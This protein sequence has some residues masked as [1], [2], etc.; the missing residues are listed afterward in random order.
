MDVHVCVLRTCMYVYVDERA[1]VCVCVCVCV[2]LQL[3]TAIIAGEH[4]VTDAKDR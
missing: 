2:S 3:G 4:V 1:C